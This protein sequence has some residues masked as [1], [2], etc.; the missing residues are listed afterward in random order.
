MHSGAEDIG[1]S[2][3]AADAGALVL[4]HISQDDEEAIESEME[5]IRRAYDGPITAARDLVRVT[6]DGRTAD[7]DTVDND[8]LVL[9]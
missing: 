9:E 7:I 5:R 8:V 1:A 3:S 4:S 6:P 2:A